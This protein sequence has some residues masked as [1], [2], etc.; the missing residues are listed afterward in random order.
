M[1]GRLVILPKKTYCPWKPENVERVLRDER[2][3]RER[4]ERETKQNQSQ[5]TVTLVRRSGTNNNNND[6]GHINLFPEAK[7]AELN[8]VRGTNKKTISSAAVDYIP[9]APL[10]GD[11]AMR[12]K[13]GIVPFYMRSISRSNDNDNSSGGGRYDN[14]GSSF[15]LGDV[16]KNYNADVITEQITRDQYA[17]REDDRKGRID[18]MNQFYKSST[19]KGGDAIIG[20]KVDGEDTQRKRKIVRQE[21]KNASQESGVEYES[22][23]ERHRH[24]TKYHRKRS[25]EISSEDNKRHR[26]RHK[27][28][29]HRDINNAIHEKTNGDE[30][31]A[32]QSNLKN[33]E[34]EELR[35]RRHVR[36]AREME[37]ER[38]V[39]NPPQ[40]NTAQGVNVYNYSREGK[41]QDQF[42]PT[43]SRN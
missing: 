27:S 33:S 1:S 26:H 6:D 4:L 28:S 20:E 39:I 32:Q 10:G 12:R 23:Y 16:R 22:R 29:S 2:L 17:R 43:L 34:L 37:R 11:E 7:D 9:D 3:E 5:S 35:R 15:R 40:L 31:K 8:L 14:N 41:Y 18:P 13:S 21:G 19:I 42:N 38:H 24:Q 36:E 25:R 30:I